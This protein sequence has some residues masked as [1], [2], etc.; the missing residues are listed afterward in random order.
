MKFMLVAFTNHGTVIT[1]LAKTLSRIASA[2][3]RVELTTILF[4]T[5]WMKSAVAK[6]YAYMIKFFIRAYDWYRE[7]TFRHVLHA[8]TRTWLKM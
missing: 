1:S 7:S 8:V 2:L 6:L 3:P 5:E 4:P